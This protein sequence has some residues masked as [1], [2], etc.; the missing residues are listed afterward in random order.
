MSDQQAQ[1]VRPS[2]ARVAPAPSRQLPRRLPLLG[3]QPP[4]LLTAFRRAP[5]WVRRRATFEQAPERRRTSKRLPGAAA[6]RQGRELSSAA[7]ALVAQRALHRWRVLSLWLLTVVVAATLVSG[8]ALYAQGVSEAALQSEL[9]TQHAPGLLVATYTEANTGPAALE[10]A[11][12]DRAD[13]AV[14]SAASATVGLSPL[15]TIAFGRT[16]PLQLAQ[17]DAGGHASVF[18]PSPTGIVAFRDGLAQAVTLDDGRLPADPTPAGGDTGVLLS[19]ETAAKYGLRP[20]D[21]FT[22]ASARA[23]RVEPIRVVIAGIWRPVDERSPYWTAIPDAR[24]S[25]VVF[26]TTRSLFMRDV[27][28]K[29][30]P[31]PE[32]SSFGWSVVFDSRGLHATNEGSVHRGLLSLGARLDQL[33]P[34]VSLDPAA[35][36]PLEAFEARLPALTS[37]LLALSVPSLAVLAYVAAVAA[38]MAMARERTE[39]AT[40][41]GRGASRGQ[42]AGSYALQGALLGAVAVAAG[43]PL[44]LAAAQAMGATSSFLVFEQGAPLP[45]SLGPR[46]F[47]AALGAVALT[48]AAVLVPA[49]EAAGTSIVAQRLEAGRSLQP[50]FVQRHGIDLLLMPVAWYA[51]DSLTRHG[52][53]VTVGRDGALQLDP[54]LLLVPALC[55]LVASLLSLRLVPWLLRGVAAALSRTP[56][57]IAL[58]AARY[59]SRQPGHSWRLLL[60]LSITVA[61]GTYSASVAHTIE[62]NQLDQALYRNGA[63]LQ[64]DEAAHVD[65]VTHQP[66]AL[67]FDLHLPLP[68]VGGATQVARWTAQ[69]AALPGATVRVLAIDPV[70]FWTVAFYR[71]SFADLPPG[72]LA[73]LLRDDEP[74][75]LVSDGFLQQSHLKRGDR[76]TLQQGA[77]SLE[78]SVAATLHA[79]PS[80]YAVDGPFVV[81]NLRYFQ[82]VLGAGASEAWLSADDQAD[83]AEI[84]GTLQS[85]GFTIDNLHD[86]RDDLRK[87]RAGVEW[88]GLSGILTAG[89]LLGALLAALGFVV[90]VVLALDQR[91]VQLGVLRATGLSSGQLAGVFAVELCLLVV[92]GLA[93]GVAIGLG[94]S[95]VFTPFL[96]VLAPADPHAS[97]PPF[98]VVVAA[99][100]TLKLAALALALFGIA[101][102][103]CVVAIRRLNLQELL[104]LGEDAA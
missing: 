63:T 29:T 102:V 66:V 49:W 8:I 16:A 97:V 65:P 24:G 11:R 93:L 78:L 82:G 6:L 99:G 95:L 36:A 44:G 103:T 96:H 83:D 68:H 80:L 101:L 7:V 34:K 87:L 67:P 50:P 73:A 58:L 4:R 26:L 31:P 48:V 59:A 9:A 1:Q 90:H 20:G 13:Q 55:I 18:T 100:D 72:D 88:R 64:V 81:A 14:R 5:A 69:S 40:L 3:W 30:P 10:P 35:L 91:G 84:V 89:F 33:L 52:A 61:M 22:L 92:L 46:A 2:P 37:L 56:S 42:M 15:Q 76:F 12:V 74:A 17:V 25:Q 60:A 43:A 94:T 86:S 47:V 19:A 57:A 53:V 45:V 77:L 32:A 28:P 41:R 104:R 98:V 39:I 71:R 27:Q 62:R 70:T 75:A 85:R 51:Y 38:G 54:L 23:F 79:F 21:R